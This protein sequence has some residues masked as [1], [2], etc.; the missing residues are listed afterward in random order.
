MKSFKRI[1]KYVWPQWHRL[2][3][4]VISAMMIGLLFAFSIGTILPLLKVMMGEEGLHGWID[5]LIAKDRYDVSFYVPD[6]IDLSD[7]NKRDIVYHLRVTAVKEGSQAAIAGLEQDDWIFGVTS[8]PT[9]QDKAGTVSSAKLLENLA[10]AESNTKLSILFKRLNADGRMENKELKIAT[11][12][13]PFYADFI[14]RAIGFVPRE[15]SRE[16][17]KKAVIFII[18]MMAVVTAIRCTARFYQDYTA[19]KVVDTSLAHLREDM[20][21]HSMDI[22][23]GFFTDKGTSDTVSRLIRDTTIIG[24]SGPDIGGTMGLRK[25]NETDRILYVSNCPGSYS[26]I[27]QKDKRCVEQGSAG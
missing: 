7:P 4:I 13:K 10:T 27:L 22:P 20:F 8:T 23:A 25:Q 17:A 1:F 14:Q 6:K 11:G 24:S 2:V 18:L 5:R 21:A 19:Q 15:Q 26:R 16:N 3:V 9:E 12:P